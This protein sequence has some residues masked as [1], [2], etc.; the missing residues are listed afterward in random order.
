MWI[1]LLALRLIDG[2]S[3][4]GSVEPPV[5]EGGGGGGRIER[6]YERRKPRKHERKY[7]YEDAPPEQFNK[8]MRAA[9]QEVKLIKPK[10]N[11]NIKQVIYN[12][13]EEDEKIAI[14]LLL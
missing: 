6:R 9:I 5:A 4:I 10:T 12:G 11:S 8:A 2:A 1:H 7:E 13:D 3:A 14:L